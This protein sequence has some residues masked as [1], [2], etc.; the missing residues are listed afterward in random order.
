MPSATTN[1][2]PATTS[3]A[4]GNHPAATSAA[5]GNHPAAATPA[6]ASS[7]ATDWLVITEHA[8]LTLLAAILIYI[9]TRPTRLIAVLD[10]VTLAAA[11]VV[12][13]P[14][15]HGLFYSNFMILYMLLIVFG[16]S[17]WKT[18][19]QPLVLDWVTSGYTIAVAAL[20]A[21]LA[22]AAFT[23]ACHVRNESRDEN[24]GPD[25]SLAAAVDVTIAAADAAITPAIV[26]AAADMWP[27]LQKQYLQD[28]YIEHLVPRNTKYNYIVLGGGKAGCVLARRLGEAKHTVLLVEKG[29]A[30]IRVF[31]MAELHPLTSMHHYSDGKHS[32]V[33]DSAPDSRF[34]RAFSLITGRGL[35]G[36]TRVNAGQFTCGVPAEYNAW[37]EDGRPGWG[38]HDLKPYF[39]K[40]QTWL[41]PVPEEYHGSSGP[42]MVW[43][44]DEYDFGSSKEAAKAANDLGF[45]PI[46]DM[47]SPL[48]PSIG[49]TKLQYT[50]ATDGMRASAFRAYLPHAVVSS[51]SNLHICVS[52][53]AGQGHFSR[54]TNGQLRADSV[55]V[56]SV[57]GGRVQAVKAK[58]EIVLACGALGSPKVLLLSG[59]G[60]QTHL[61]DMGIEVVRDT[62]GVGAHLQDHVMVP[63]VYNC[64]LSDSLWLMF[65]RPYMLFYQLFLYLFSE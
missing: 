10:A 3:A 60:P 11:A 21:A 64:P 34:G 32:T 53:V 31:K 43:S 36:T 18:P 19:D 63:T 38:Y 55:Q 16:T 46:V 6:A 54:E 4:N 14:G 28:S 52:A 40:S 9:V 41:G 25:I 7:P 15:E 44:Y 17:D 35:G 37:S 26:D 48:Q 61:E 57:D 59:V 45:V 65:R 20:R 47:H 12:K 8:F 30:G 27:S 62:P 49:W 58:R 42:L 33:F 1:N 23:V 29:D 2:H 50:V 56:L 22:I 39:A 24:N 13:L 51:L 5:N